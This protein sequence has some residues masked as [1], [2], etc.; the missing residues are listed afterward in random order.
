MPPPFLYDLAELQRHANRLYGLS[1]KRTLE[2][3]QTLYEKHKV[4]TYPCTDSRHL[5]SAV[6]SRLRRIATYVA[7]NFD[8]CLVAGSTGERPLGKRFVDDSKVTDHHAIIPTGACAT[9]IAPDSPEGKILDLVNRRLLQAWHGD[10]KYSSTTV[11]TR[12]SLR[13]HAD[14]FLSTGTVVDDIGWKILDFKIEKKN[15][16]A[17]EEPE[18][19]EGLV[20]GQPVKVLRAEPVETRA[21]PSAE[22]AGLAPARK[23]VAGRRNRDSANGRPGGTQMGLGIVPPREAADELLASGLGAWRKSEAQRRGVPAFMIFNNLTLDALVAAKPT[24]EAQLLGVPGVGAVVAK[25]YGA[26]LIQIIRHA[27]S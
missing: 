24:N 25:K 23:V 21:K 11:I 19:P 26:K 3:A 13:E 16:T 15:G 6:A 7:A 27:G 9:G 2:P 12:I 4:I 10:H 20:Q 8:E 5:S 22:G 17:S 14:Q 18:L 1:A